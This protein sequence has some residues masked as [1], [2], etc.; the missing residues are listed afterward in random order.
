MIGRLRRLNRLF[1]GEQKRCLLSPLDHGGWLGPVKGIDRP[2][3]I[4]KAVLEGGANAL[5]ISPGFYKA[6]API[7]PPSVGIVLRVSLTAGLSQ[8]GAQE[9]PISSLETALRMDAD[10]IAVSVFFGRAGDVEIY[11]WLAKL[12]DASQTYD[13]PVVAEMMPPGDRFYEPEA[14]AHAARIGMEIGADVIKTNYSGDVKSFTEIVS[15][16]PVPI[17]VAGGPKKEGES[18]ASLVEDIAA[19]GAA[20]V[21]I[22]RRVWQ[23]ADPQAVT[24]EIHRALFT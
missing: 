23:S 12:V 22:G 11:R 4:V 13:M 5:L 17:I 9:T 2:Q 19:A 15:A 16:N 3:T 18:T 8:D 20:G 14:I 7:V 10:A 21:A 1:V 6:V 24:A